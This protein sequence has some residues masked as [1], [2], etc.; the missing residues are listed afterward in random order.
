MQLKKSFRKGCHIFATHMEEATKHKMES[1]EDHL[2]LK[3][4]GDVSRG[5]PGLPPR[6]D[7][8]FSIDLVPGVAPVSKTPY[9]MGTLEFK[10]LQM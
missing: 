4:F 9:K 5:I 10:E 3:D 8:H 7:I 6:R 1:I 2:V